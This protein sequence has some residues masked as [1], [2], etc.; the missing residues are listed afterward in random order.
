[1]KKEEI[2][3][4]AKEYNIGQHLNVD[5]VEFIVKEDYIPEKWRYS[6]GVGEIGRG[7][8]M[9]DNYHILIN[10]RCDSST[11]WIDHPTVACIQSA[12]FHRRGAVGE[13]TVYM[14]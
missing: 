10:E 12:H 4:L 8:W 5:K 13:I 6:N 11:K 2:I 1:M 7:R 9:D 14:K 3:E